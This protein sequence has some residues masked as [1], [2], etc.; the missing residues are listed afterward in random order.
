M[1]DI[2]NRIVRELILFLTEDLP[3]QR[4]ESGLRR[5][6]TI[7]HQVNILEQELVMMS[8]KWDSP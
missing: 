4:F 6:E 8:N 3:R 5:I 2:V 1:D 7:R